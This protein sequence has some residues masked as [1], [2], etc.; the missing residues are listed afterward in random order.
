MKKLVFHF[1][2]T[3][4]RVESELYRVHYECLSKYSGIF[5]EVYYTLS[6]DDTSDHDLIH[7]FEHRLLDITRCGN[8]TFRVVQN[9]KY[10]EAETFRS[11]VV[12]RLGSDDLVFFGHSKGC[13]NLGNFDYE[14]L[15]QW[16]VGM[17]YF[18]LNFMD[19]VEKSLY[20]RPYVS[21][22]PFLTFNDEKHDIRKVPVNRWC[23]IGTFFWIN[24]RKLN[25]WIKL[26]GAHVPSMSDRFYAEEFLGNLSPHSAFG[27]SHGNRFGINMTDYYN[28]AR[29]YIRII[30]DGYQYDEFMEFYNEVISG[31]RKENG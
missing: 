11:Q 7:S 4:E 20:N 25:D 24:S 1:F 23:Y 8:V 27:Y 19:E 9:D 29:E 14:S 5:D 22:G 10:C 12:S 6:L 3:R 21:Y 2:I 16:V 18:S 15:L 31:V 13:S 30:Y 26:T 28:N 17:Y